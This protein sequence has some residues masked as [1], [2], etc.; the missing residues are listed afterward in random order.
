MNGSFPDRK[1]AEDYVK[2]HDAE[3]VGLTRLSL[4]KLRQVEQSALKASGGQRIA[5]G[6][7]GR[8]ELIASTLEIHYPLIAEARAVL[9]TPEAQ[10]PAFAMSDEDILKLVQEDSV[11]GYS[12][13]VGEY[14]GYVDWNVGEGVL[15]VTVRPYTAEADDPS[16]P[17]VRSWRL[18]PVIDW[19]RRKS[20][21]L[22]KGERNHLRHLLQE[23]SEHAR[24]A[25]NAIEP[26]TGVLKVT[27]KA[28]AW[29][30]ESLTAA[31]DSYTD[32]ILGRRR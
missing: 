11:S 15:T 19:E 23:L 32:E 25:R 4:L 29:Q 13:G 10:A 18:V 27:D 1:A 6:P 9:A 24:G 3:A 12:E 16:G 14:G 5:G 30:M 7:V 20:R 28:W 2:H 26:E 31:L 21:A 22:D 17:V 8:D